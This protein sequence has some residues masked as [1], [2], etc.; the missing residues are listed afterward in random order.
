M[1]LGDWRFMFGFISLHTIF[2]KGSGFRGQKSGRIEPDSLPL[3]PEPSK[4]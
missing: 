3:K 1:H 2:I 4:K